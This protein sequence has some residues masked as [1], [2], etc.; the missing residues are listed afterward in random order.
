MADIISE[1][2]KTVKGMY[3]SIFPPQNGMVTNTRNSGMNTRGFVPVNQQVKQETGI[4]FMSAGHAKSR[5]RPVEQVDMNPT[6]NG[7]K[8]NGS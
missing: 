6:I 5:V 2:Y 8:F 1:A 7:V 4:K 3:D